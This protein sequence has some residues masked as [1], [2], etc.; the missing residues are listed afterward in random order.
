[1]DFNGKTTTYAY[2]T[3]NRLLSKTPDVS[4][5]TSPIAFTYNNL[6]LRTTMTDPSGSTSYTYDTRNRLTQKQTPAGTLNYTYDNAGDVLTIASSN[7]NGVSLAYTY[8][9][10]NRLATV[11]DNRLLAQGAASGTTTYNYDTVG[12]LQDFTYPNGV[13]HAYSY[14][15]LNRLTQVGASKNATALSNY[16]YTLGAAGNRTS[17]AE[18]S[19]R[20]VAYGYDALYRLTSEAITADPANHNGTTQYTYDAV[21]NRQQWVVNGVT[22]NS[23]TYD[24]N[25]RLGSDQYDANG[26]TTNSLGAASTYDFENHLVQKGAV[27]IVYDGDGNRVSETV[28]GVTTK[29]LVDTLN[30]TG[31]AQVVDELVSGAVTRTYAYGLE[32]ISE[33]QVISSTWTPSFYGYDGHG[34]VRQLTNS[35]GVV[36][37]TYDYDAFG[38]LTSSRG[39]TPNNYLFAGEQYD[40]ALGLYYNRARYLNTTAGRFWSVDTWEGQDNDP[41]SLHKY[42]FA[43]ANPINRV[44]PSGHYDLVEITA[45]IA[46]SI[47]LLTLP[48][49]NSRIPLITVGVEFR[50]TWDLGRNPEDN[51]TAPEQDTVKYVAFQTMRAAY[52]GYGVIFSEGPGGGRHIYVNN[53]LGPGVGVTYVINKYSDLYF[54]N[55][56]SRLE[57]VLDC[58]AL[59]GCVRKGFDRTVVAAALGRGIGATAAHEL[60]HQAGLNFVQD[61]PCDDCYDSDTADTFAHYFDILHWSDGAK[62]RMKN[63]LPGGPN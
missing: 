52:S 31:Y 3:L 54:W 22:V 10:L 24:S 19:G 8:D 16:A 38:N 14:D 21:G 48:A 30:P 40:P 18:L 56:W 1:V 9:T 2:D 6:G 59:S 17:V 28:G 35:A 33:N 55:L 23:Y 7:T 43:R 42:A 29:Y 12:N 11:T 51:L 13:K 25:D 34:S 36:T 37:D 5:G 53:Q 27:T 60:G 4:F 39:S 15:M 58:S 32:R 57:S 50:N 45:A 49:C 62:A 44:D 61:I 26:N 41:L 46:I 63:V 47:T 20:T